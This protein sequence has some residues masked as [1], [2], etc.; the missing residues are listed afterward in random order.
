MRVLHVYRTYPID[1]TTGVGE[2]IRQ[3]ALATADLG[4]RSRIFTLSYDPRPA[5][6]D[7][8]E[9]RL[10]RAR[11]WASPAS[12]D[13]GLWQA[14]RRF[15]E[16]AQWAD[17]IQ[18]H[19]PWPFGDLLRAFAANGRPSVLTYHSDVVGK[20]A[21]G[22][23]YAP[24]MR[25]TLAGMHAIVATSPA[26]ARTSPV[27]AGYA[28]DPRL[29][30][31]PLGVREQTYR[32]ALDEAARVDVVERHGLP[33]GDYFL[34]VGALRRYKGLEYLLSAA[35]RCDLPLAVAGSGELEGMLR[36]ARQRQRNLWWLGHVTDAEK[37]ALL[38][39]CRALVLPSHLRSEAF[40]LIL[41]EA[42]M[43]GVPM[44]CCEIG[45]GTSY[46]NRDGETG[47]VVPPADSDALAAAMERLAGD[48]ALASGMG[49]RA[50]Q[51]YQQRFSGD[52]LGQAY[53]S[54]YHQ[55][56]QG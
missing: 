9:G 24:L 5:E 22:R 56:L 13:I 47:L 51:R 30:V 41:V 18:Y 55:A 46:I 33:R 11:A 16:Q 26:Y 21:L 44:I 34:F 39:D 45:T 2:A 6:R 38:R 23:L 7:L 35:R 20:G 50:R 8:E 37:F 28:G 52:S 1:Q 49:Q 17:L 10:V 12:C 4:V 19:F 32:R 53:R 25:R 29:R 27:L 48:D 14:W 3:I 36:Q 54:L 31:I 42:A 43:C 40:G 15:R